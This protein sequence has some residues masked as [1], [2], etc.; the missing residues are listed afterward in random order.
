[1]RA[2]LLRECG[3]FRFVGWFGWPRG[4]VRVFSRAATHGTPPPPLLDTA[5]APALLGNG[6]GLRAMVTRPARSGARTVSTAA[7]YT[8]SRSAA[9]V[10]FPRERARAGVSFRAASRFHPR[11][12]KKLCRTRAHF[13]RGSCDHAVATLAPA[14][15]R[16]RHAKRS[17]LGIARLWRHEFVGR[18]REVERLIEVLA[19]DHHERGNADEVAARVEQAATGRAR[20]DR[21]G[22]LH[23]APLIF[24][25]HARKH[26]SRERELEAVRHRARLV[27]ATRTSP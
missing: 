1:M 17:S 20:R 15:I 18:N 23:V 24:F 21:R 3:P 26:T 22:G 19:A 12:G 2:T 11:S 7:T 16:V 27:E 10:D 5:A 6:S 9:R 14:V 13:A 25:A 4:K 8:M